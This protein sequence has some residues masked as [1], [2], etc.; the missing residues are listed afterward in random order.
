MIF[1]LK[2]VKI[3]Q[4]EDS[5]HADSC[6]VCLKTCLRTYGA[7]GYDHVLAN[8][9]PMMREFGISDADIDTMLRKNPADFLC[10]KE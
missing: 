9:V 7:W 10:G 8:V 2:T 3:E 1:I 5:E 4:G 6:D